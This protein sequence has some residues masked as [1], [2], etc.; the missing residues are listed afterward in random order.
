M[1]VL[2]A[3]IAVVMIGVAIQAFIKALPTLIKAGI[4]L[5]IA[6]FTFAVLLDQPAAAATVLS[7][8]STGASLWLKKTMITGGTI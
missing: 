5:G 4:G 6:Y 3:L 1:E 8:G 7:V 2:G